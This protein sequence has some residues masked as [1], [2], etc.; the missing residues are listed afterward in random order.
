MLSPLRRPWTVVSPLDCDGDAKQ[1]ALHAFN[2]IR[3]SRVLTEL[4]Q[5]RG[6]PPGTTGSVTNFSTP[7]IFKGRVYVGTQTGISVFGLCTSCPH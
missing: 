1:A 3:G 4:Y 6:L 5:S 7:T 2:A